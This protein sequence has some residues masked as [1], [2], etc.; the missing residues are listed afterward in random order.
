MQF[1]N[2]SFICNSSTK[3]IKNMFSTYVWP[4][5]F[6]Q[7]EYQQYSFYPQAMM[8]IGYSGLQSTFIPINLPSTD[9][10]SE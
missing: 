4:Y 10:I 3:N 9:E 5:S 8:N 1:K 7:T 6:I 2:R